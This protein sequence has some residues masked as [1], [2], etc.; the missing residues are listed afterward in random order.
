M[1]S[2]RWWGFVGIVRTRRDDDGAGAE[3]GTLRVGRPE[4]ILERE[5]QAVVEAGVLAPQQLR[6]GTLQHL[7]V[8]HTEVRDVVF[9][10]DLDET[11][12][13]RGVNRRWRQRRSHC[14]AA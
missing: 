8:A 12:H 7:G 13:V 10:S 1:R 4:G 5:R 3:N 14:D 2:G 9:A 11:V 6:P